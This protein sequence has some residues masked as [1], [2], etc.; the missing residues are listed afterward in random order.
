MNIIFR[1]LLFMVSI[2]VF[3]LLFLTG[4]ATLKNEEVSKESNTLYKDVSSSSTTSNQTEEEIILKSI[5]KLKDKSYI[6]TTPDETTLYTAVEELYKIGKPVIPYLITNLDTNDDYERALTFF[7]LRLASQ[8][9]SIKQFTKGNFIDINLDFDDRNHPD[10]KI[11]A[12]TWW[13]KY[14]NYWD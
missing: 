4:C 3:V 13:E 2:I 6:T 5:N 10:M 7:A 9:D 14:R 11:I 12:T 1:K 8:D